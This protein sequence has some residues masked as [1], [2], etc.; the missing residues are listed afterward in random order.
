MRC[1]VVWYEDINVSMKSSASFIYFDEMSVLF[2][3]TTWC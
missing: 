2:Y 3:N 1:S